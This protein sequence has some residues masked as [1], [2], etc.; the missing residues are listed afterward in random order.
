MLLLFSARTNDF[1][2]INDFDMFGRALKPP[3][4]FS[5][6]TSASSHKIFSVA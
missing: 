6:L 1:K 5:E 4:H 3:L 2:L